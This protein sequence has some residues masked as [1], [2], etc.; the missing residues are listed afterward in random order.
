MEEG[1]TLSFIRTTKILRH[2]FDERVITHLSFTF[3]QGIASTFVRPRKVLR[4]F[5][6]RGKYYVISNAEES[7]LTSSFTSAGASIYGVSHRAEALPVYM[8]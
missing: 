5:Q 4:Y 6:G 7:I 8:W 1:A 2:N 3:E